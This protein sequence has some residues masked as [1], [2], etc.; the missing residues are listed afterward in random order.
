LQIIQFFID[1]ILHVDQKLDLLIQAFGVWTYL[2]VFVVIFCETGLVV[3]PFLPGDSLL[4]AAGALAARGSLNVAALFFL[5]AFAAIIGDSVNY[6]IG[7]KLG[8]AVLHR[9][10][11]RVFKKAYLD[12]THAFFQRHGGKAVVLG[13]FVPIVRTFVPFLAGVG[14]MRYRQFITLNVIGGVIWV[15]LFTFA[16]YFFGSLPWVEERFSLVILAVIAISVLPALVEYVRH[17]L[18]GRD[19]PAEERA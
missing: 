1:F 19:G 6:A 15:S 4:F 12:Q 5:L 11:S 16:G 14:E 7:H 10:D 13:R 3:T 17:K 2:I 9:E 8:P 18:A